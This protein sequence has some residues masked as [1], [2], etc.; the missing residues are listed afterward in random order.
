MLDLELVVCHRVMNYLSGDHDQLLK[1]ALPLMPIVSLNV[2]KRF[3]HAEVMKGHQNAAF[4]FHKDMLNNTLDSIDHGLREIVDSYLER[5]FRSHQGSFSDRVRHAI[6]IHLSG[7]KANKTDIANMLAMH[8]RSLQRKL[9]EKGTSFEQIRDKLRQQ[10][11]LQYLADSKASMSKSLLC[12]G[13][14]SSQH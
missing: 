14:P 3:F 11:L 7:P 8:P 10:L 9:D 4:Y 1:V 12:W 5:S 13:F 6:R 2:Y